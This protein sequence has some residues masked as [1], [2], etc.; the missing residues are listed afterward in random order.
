[1]YINRFINFFS[2]KKKSKMD[3]FRI[4]RLH[5]LTNNIFTSFF[6]ELKKILSKKLVC[7]LF[8]KSELEGSF[9][10]LIVNFLN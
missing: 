10:S 7:F 9:K 1:M 2:R 5:T 4:N 3:Q 8:F 6:Q